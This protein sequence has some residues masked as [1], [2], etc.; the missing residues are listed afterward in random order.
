MVTLP[1]RVP[2]AAQEA[3]RRAMSAVCRGGDPI[4]SLQQ[5]VEL[6]PGFAAALADLDLLTGRDEAA[7]PPEGTTSW[8]RRHVEIIAT[9]RTDAVRA[10]A[11]LRDHATRSG[12]DPLA[13]LAVARRLDGIDGARLRD[14]RGDLCTC[15]AAV[16]LR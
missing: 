4:P 3:Y 11:L 6:D 16:M 13:L 12:C 14:M 7:H 1:I 2:A 8:E 5:A 15:P 10:E 9:S